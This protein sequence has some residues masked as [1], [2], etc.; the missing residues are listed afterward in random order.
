MP[1]R[2]FPPDARAR[3]RHGD[4]GLHVRA[5]CRRR[6]R[7]T[8]SSPS[9]RSA[10]RSRRS[11]SCPFAWGSLGVASAGRA[12]GRRGRGRAARDRLRP[13]DCRPRADDGLEHGLHHG[14]VRRPDPD[15]RAR[16]LPHP[17]GGGGLGRRGARGR[18]PA[19]AERRPRAAPR[20]ATRSSSETP[21]P[22]R[23][24]SSRWSGSRHATTRAR[25]RS[26]RWRSRA[27]RSRRSRSRGASS[28]C[29]ATGRSGTRSS[30]RASSRGRSATSS[31]PGCSRAPPRRVRRSSSRS[32]RRS[33]RSSACCS[34]PSAW[35]GSGGPA[36][37][38]CS[39]GSSLAEPAAAGD[40]APPRPPYR[41]RLMDAV[42]LALCSAALFGGM[43]VA[44]RP[45]LARGDD[46][47]V[48]ALLTVLPA[49]WRR[50]DR[51]DDRRGLERRRGLAVR[52]SPGSSR[53]GVSQVLF[54]LAIRDAGPSRASAT[55]GMAPL[56]A[57]T[58]AA[59]LL[60]EP[61]VAGIVVGA[62]LIVGGGILL[63]SEG[64]RPDHVKTIGLVL[65]L[66]GGLRLRLA[67]HVR[68]LARGRHG[69]L[70]GARDQRDAPRGSGDDP[71]RGRVEPA[72][73]HSRVAACLRSG[74]VALRAL[75][76]LAVRG[77]L[78]WPAQRRR[79]ARRDRVAVGGGAV[80][81]LPAP[82][83]GRRAPARRRG[84]ASSS[85]AGS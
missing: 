29:R 24:R 43:T 39:P 3:R 84:A 1:G 9:S 19:A 80:G 10:S 11:C 46:P 74:R 67:R 75:L 66:A 82:D 20:S 16:A 21:S 71:G 6:S 27:W 81:P 70:A 48:G 77:V 53:P 61:L 35:A 5:R 37:R 72:S 58:F 83:R 2:R 49:L 64:G 60:G 85:P 68:P 62:V 31:R 22:S 36:A 15:A 26:C 14:A 69:R 51:R 79:A 17:G 65:A 76:R 30:S 4:L 41:A 73:P 57:V 55:V 52:R 56:F 7:S 44:L 59:V 23:S 45:A 40:A 33:R 13:A 42:V 8:R 18:R 50:A 47:L 78:P 34:S 25:S 12:R 54:T 38:S 32:R 28:R 63:A